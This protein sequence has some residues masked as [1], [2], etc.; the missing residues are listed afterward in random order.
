MTDESSD[1]I[2]RLYSRTNGTVGLVDNLYLTAQQNLEAAYQREME[3]YADA[4]RLFRICSVS[5]F[6]E[7]RFSRENAF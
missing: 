2:M 6:G 4:N 3:P 1:A 5:Y 7:R